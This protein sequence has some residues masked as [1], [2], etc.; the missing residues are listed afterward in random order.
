M[1]PS[2]KI[3]YVNRYRQSEPYKATREWRGLLAAALLVTGR[4]AEAY[5][6]DLGSKGE[7][8][9]LKHNGCI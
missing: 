1:F 2:I 7:K 4:V 9:Q 8:A 3:S 6:L 5:K